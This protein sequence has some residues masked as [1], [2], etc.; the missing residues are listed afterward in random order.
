MALVA[1][2]SARCFCPAP[3]GARATPPEGHPDSNCLTTPPAPVRRG[4]T[5]APTK[6]PRHRAVCSWLNREPSCAPAR[7]VTPSAV[8]R[9]LFTRRPRPRTCRVGAVPACPSPQAGTPAPAAP[10]LVSKATP[11]HS[12]LPR[13]RS[14]LPPVGGRRSRTIRPWAGGET[15]PEKERES[16][17]GSRRPHSPAGYRFTR[18]PAPLRSAGVP[19]KLPRFAAFA[20]APERFAH[21][22]RLLAVGGSRVCLPLRSRGLCLFFLPVR[23]VGEHRKK[24]WWGVSLGVAVECRSKSRPPAR[25]EA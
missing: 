3:L 6:P 17:P 21:L 25:R 23:R 13:P 10:G 18:P 7:P 11:S 16:R 2:R 12:L 19:V 22:S 4:R 15:G 5:T 24:K 8:A 9:P 14:L 20:P 1:G